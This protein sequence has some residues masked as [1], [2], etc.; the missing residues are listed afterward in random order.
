MFKSVFSKYFTVTA[1]LLLVAMVVLGGAQILFLNNYWMG[2]KREQLTENAS[3]VADHVA[4][5]TIQDSGN[6]FS[7]YISTRSVSPIIDL[8]AKSLNANVLVVDPNGKI[9]TAATLTPLDTDS[10]SRETLSRIGESF[11]E[12]GNMD[13]LFSSAYYTAA[14]PI[15]VPGNVTVGYVIAAMPADEFVQYIHETF[16]TYLISAL[17]VLLVFSVIIYIVTYRLVKPLRE[18]SAAAKRFAEGDFSC[19]IQVRGQDEVAQLEQAF[20]A[21]AI[22]LSSTEDMSRSFVAN[23]SHEL[24]TPMTTIGGFVDGIL[25]GTIPPD[26]QNY[27]LKIVS[28]EVKR[29]SQLV[30]AM[31]DLSRI[32][33]GSLRINPVLVDLTDIASSCLLSF[34]QRIEQK[35][36]RVEGLSECDRVEV[37]ADRDLI[38]QVIYNLLD[39]AVKFVD[40][41][42]TITVR[43]EQKNNRVI[44][45]VRNT[46]EGLS[47]EEMPRVFER[48]YKTDRSRSR[49]KTGVGLGLYIVKTVINLHKGEITVRSVQGEYCEFVFWLPADAGVPDT[50][51]RHDKPRRSANDLSSERQ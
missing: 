6:P 29:L 7:Y 32:D 11:Y 3:L 5:V 41:G 28:D 43:I 21:M 20:N 38:G 2:D 1:S 51:N 8:V 39:N 22:S 42:G 24:K 10:V 40:E 18:M 34:E 4:S 19:R 15:E 16:R 48:F 36:V 17:V 50:G 26:K 45:A 30:N 13:G 9:L 31:L 25:D 12:V 49:D 35:H 47:P 27:Y 44:C 14:T 46:G 37:I 23:V 33:N